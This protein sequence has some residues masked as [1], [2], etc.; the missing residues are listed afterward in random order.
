MQIN[1]DIHEQ[2]ASGDGQYN[3]ISK[4]MWKIYKALIK[5]TPELLDYVVVIPPGGQTDAIVQTII[6]WRFDGKTFKTRGL[7]GDQ[8]VAAYQGHKMKMLKHPRIGKYSG[9]QLFSVTAVI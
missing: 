7:H 5:P 4:A 1:G 9:Y 6:T 2:S 3:A 8:T